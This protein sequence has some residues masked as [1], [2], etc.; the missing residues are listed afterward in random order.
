MVNNLL[1]NIFIFILKENLHLRLAS[2]GSLVVSSVFVILPGTRLADP[3]SLA[4][5]RCFNYKYTL[6]RNGTLGHFCSSVLSFLNPF[7]FLQVLYMLPVSG[8]QKYI[9]PKFLED[10][11]FLE[12]SNIS[13]SYNLLFS[14]SEYIPES[15]EN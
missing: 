13:G 7:E 8:V 4:E 15:W 5:P 3:L 10:D 1:K 11:I 6:V 14:F 2:A 12:S 9:S